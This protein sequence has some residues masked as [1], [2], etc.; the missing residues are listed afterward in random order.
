MKEEKVPPR[1][2]RADN[3]CSFLG[4]MRIYCPPPQGITK[5]NF[6]VTNNLE[7]SLTINIYATN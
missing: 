6:F 2:K 7:K 5:D 1:K 3:I 4:E